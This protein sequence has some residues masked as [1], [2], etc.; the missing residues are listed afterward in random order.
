M[1]K[2][3]AARRPTAVEGTSDRRKE[4]KRPRRPP[5]VIKRR[6]R[7]R[8]LS[9]FVGILS[10]QAAEALRRAIAKSR[11]ERERPDRE[12]LD[13]LLRAFDRSEDTSVL[14]KA[15]QKAQSAGLTRSKV[16]DLLREVKKEAW[17][18]R[19]G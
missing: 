5:D 6:T 4:P 13:W 18:R 2:T 3:R 9:D 19:Y 15:A 14:D 16:E 17:I 11:K 8:P 12:R 10:P 1:T 7:R